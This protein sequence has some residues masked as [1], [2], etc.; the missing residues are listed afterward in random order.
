M[1]NWARFG[2]GGRRKNRPRPTLCFFIATRAEPNQNRPLGHI[3]LKN[4]LK[5]FVFSETIMN[6]FILV[7]IFLRVIDYSKI[8]DKI[9]FVSV[10]FF[11]F[12]RNFVF[13]FLVKFDPTINL[14]RKLD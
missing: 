13:I 3:R 10:A 1:L 6:L 11:Y 8:L 12:F 7:N 14:I 2:L 9:S 5:I 4:L